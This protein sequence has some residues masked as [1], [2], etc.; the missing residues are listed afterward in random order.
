MNLTDPSPH[1][2]IYLE[3]HQTQETLRLELF[4]TP[5]PSR[6]YELRVNGSRYA[7][8]QYATKTQVW[9]RLRKWMVAHH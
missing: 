2:T 1:F 5:F 6:K 3:N 4:D 7:K 9:D 8:W